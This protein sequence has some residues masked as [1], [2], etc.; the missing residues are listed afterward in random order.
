MVRAGLRTARAPLTHK[1]APR[2]AVNP[3]APTAVAGGRKCKAI[4][5]SATHASVPAASHPSS[6][7]ID[8]NS[9]D[10]RIIKRRVGRG[11]IEGF[12]LHSV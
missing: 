12:L 3:D 9:L 5:T 8:I 11:G 6:T 1:S 10:K 2:P 4:A 7:N